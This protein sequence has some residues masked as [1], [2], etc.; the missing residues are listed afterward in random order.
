MKF[1]KRILSLFLSLLMV[2]TSIPAFAVTVSADT[3]SDYPVDSVVFFN[4]NSYTTTGAKIGDY[5]GSNTDSSKG[6]TLTYK[7][8]NPYGES[9]TDVIGQFL[10]GETGTKNR[11]LEIF[12]IIHMYYNYDGSFMDFN[13]NDIAGMKSYANEP[14]QFVLQVI[15][16]GEFDRVVIYLNDTKVYSYNMA[17]KTYNNG[18]DSSR[19]LREYFKLS[20]IG[21]YANATCGHWTWDTNTPGEYS[22]VAVFND[23]L[24]PDE[25]TAYVSI[26]D[27]DYSNVGNTLN[28]LKAVMNE[29]EGI[30][31]DSSITKTNLLDAYNAYI[32]ASKIYDTVYYGENN[33][34]AETIKNAVY[35]LTVAID[36]MTEVPATVTGNTVPVATDTWFSSS[37]DINYLMRINNRENNTV[38]NNILYSGNWNKDGMSKQDAGAVTQKL[39]AADNPVILYTGSDNKAVIPIMVSSYR[40]TVNERR[41]WYCSPVQNANQSAENNLST[42]WSLIK[43]DWYGGSE[44]GN[45]AWMFDVGWDGNGSDWYD[46]PR[47]S[48]SYNSNI[49]NTVVLTNRKDN[50]FVNAIQFEGTP[51]QVGTTYTINFALG[52]GGD[53]LADTTY[54]PYS[55]IRVINYKALTDAISSKI[56]SYNVGDYTCGGLTELFTAV[57]N[58]LAIE[59]QNYFLDGTDS[60]YDECVSAIES[61]ISTINSITPTPDG[62]GYQS[63]RNVLD[64]EF[65]ETNGLNF[66]TKS[67]D[68]YRK[69]IEYCRAYMAAVYSGYTYG[70]VQ[71][72]SGYAY[73]SDMQ[74]LADAASNV[75]NSKVDFSELKSLVDAAKKLDIFD[76]NGVQ[77]KTFESWLTLQNKISETQTQGEYFINNVG[78]HG[79]DEGVTIDCT[80]GSI[81]YD[82]INLDLESTAF[83]F[84]NENLAYYRNSNNLLEDVPKEQIEAFDAA[85]EVGS[86]VPETVYKADI[87]EVQMQAMETAR[88][89]I[90]ISAE[91]AT[92]AGYTFPE[93]VD[94][95]ELV[96]LSDAG[97]VDAQTTAVLTAIS[98][99][100][101]S[102]AEFT[103]IVNDVADEKTYKYGDPYTLEGQTTNGEWKIKYGDNKTINI[104]VD[105]YTP[106]DLIVEDNIEATFTSKVVGSETSYAV[107]IYDGYGKLVEIRYEDNAV[108]EEYGN[109]NLTAASVPFYDFTGWKFETETTDDS[110]TIYK[111]T[112]QYTAQDDGTVLIQQEGKDVKRA[113]FDTAVTLT[114]DGT[115]YGW[116]NKIETET[117]TV[118]YQIVSYSTDKFKSYAISPCNYYP[119]YKDNDGTYYVMDGESKVTLTDQNVDGNILPEGQ[120]VGA[121]AND[122]LKFKLDNKYPFVY[123]EKAVVVE[124]ATSDSKGRYRAYAR[125][126]DGADKYE[127]FGVRV[128]VGDGKL[129]GKFTCNN[130]AESNQFSFTINLTQNQVTGVD[131]IT[132]KP[133]VNHYFKYSEKPVDAFY[134]SEIVLNIS[135]QGGV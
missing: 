126:T 53:N 71:L 56:F 45:W 26:L 69:M 42:E 24:S 77:I 84:N 74:K 112:P 57:D 116:V 40:D 98:T 3:T 63:V 47:F 29:Y 4:S 59:P 107:Y 81:T 68:D 89:E 50:S 106:V 121:T 5:D 104:C 118:K 22:D 55:N 111:F 85:Y 36:L 122:H 134:T 123:T 125:F 109:I 14:C 72:Q 7:F 76:E 119:F 28:D 27:K 114:S 130:K 113:S 16:N 131:N 37:N 110:K 54:H 13:A 12:P 102:K 2:V 79:V 91:E 33:L 73:N 11:Y 129:D 90:Y 105:A 64:T 34:D 58:A 135:G 70:S 96:Y 92:N 115:N 31:K 124:N 100:D 46:I 132:F 65:D 97:S 78:Q 25:V 41:F 82:R 1:S 61:A 9:Y 52:C 66:T 38:F 99:L 48:A 108:T 67:F 35:N 101:E 87:R 95:Q 133:Y 21:V 39:F 6:Y 51:T 8:K 88:A 30:M 80:V 44:D 18:L 94:K 20:N 43:P 62:D 93:G 128:I 127:S 60:R 17:D 83:A 103:V 10:L 75:L 120:N 15:P 86:T 32:E 23:I 19:P 117:G 49:Q